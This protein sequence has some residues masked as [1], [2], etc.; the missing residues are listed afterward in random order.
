[1]GKAR[2]I[3]LERSLGLRKQPGQTVWG[4]I[5][6]G[7]RLVIPTFKDVQYGAKPMMIPIPP[8]QRNRR[9]SRNE[10]LER[11]LSAFMH[12]H[13]KPTHSKNDLD[14]LD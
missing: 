9:K 6:P 12:P 10:N 13:P 7:M 14:G 1:M 4:E 11:T 8:S 5:K 3:K 2:R